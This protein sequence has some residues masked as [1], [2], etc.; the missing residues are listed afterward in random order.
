VQSG[1]LSSQ[2]Q[3]FVFAYH[4]TSDYKANINNG[5]TAGRV[6]LTTNSG[7]GPKFNLEVDAGNAYNFPAQFN[8]NF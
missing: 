5:Y 2:C 6:A 3:A 4:S 8:F 1:L 7:P